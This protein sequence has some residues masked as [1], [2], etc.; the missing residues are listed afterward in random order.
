MKP[1]ENA[2]YED[3][4]SQSIFQGQMGFDHKQTNSVQKLRD[5]FILVLGDAGQRV[6]VRCGQVWL[7]EDLY[8]SLPERE[9]IQGLILFN[10]VQ[11]SGVN[12]H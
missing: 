6:E 12:L 10:L 5:L 4:L 2:G 8:E 3:P 9:V 11:V 1:K 7:V